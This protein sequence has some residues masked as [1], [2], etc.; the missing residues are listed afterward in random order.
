MIVIDPSIANIKLRLVPGEV[1]LK[2]RKFVTE[3]IAKRR[4]VSF[5]NDKILFQIS[6]F[7][8]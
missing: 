1:N 8:K 6:P 3:L 5:T 7:V 2:R 4:K